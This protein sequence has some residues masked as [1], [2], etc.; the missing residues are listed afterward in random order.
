MQTSGNVNKHQNS[1][2]AGAYHKGSLTHYSIT[3]SFASLYC[4][5][6]KLRYYKG[7]IEL[8]IEK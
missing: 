3:L 5:I 6:C 8:G 4:V 1:L 7:V 2:R